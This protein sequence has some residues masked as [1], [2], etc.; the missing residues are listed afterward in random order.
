MPCRIS[1]VSGDRTRTVVTAG[2]P[3]SSTITLRSMRAPAASS[4][5]SLVQAVRPPILRP[6]AGLLPSRTSSRLAA[7]NSSN[8]TVWPLWKAESRGWL[9][10]NL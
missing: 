1:S 4:V 2:K 9:M 8:P 3:A 10:R 7:A 6:S 5:P